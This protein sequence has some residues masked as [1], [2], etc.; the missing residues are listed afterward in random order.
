LRQQSR[1]PGRRLPK[2]LVQPPKKSSVATQPTVIMLAYSAMK[3]HG[4]L[5][6]AVFGVIAGSEFGLGFGQIER[7]AVGF[8]IRGHQV[9]EESYELKAAEDVPGEETVGGLLP[10]MVR[11]FNEPARITTPTRERPSAS[12]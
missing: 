8:G 5:H 12:S 2:G 1:R 3:E 10:T 6:R 7:G 4:E 11:R 9:D